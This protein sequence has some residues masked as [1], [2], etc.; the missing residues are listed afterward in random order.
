MNITTFESLLICEAKLCSCNNKKKVVYGFSEPV[1]GICIDKN[2][3]ILSQIQACNNLK[4]ITTDNLEIST[5]ERE[6]KDLNAIL[7]D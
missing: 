5:I 7:I 4:N 3:L 1:H 6:L 2:Q